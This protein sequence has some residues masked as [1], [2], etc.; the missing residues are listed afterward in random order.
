MLGAC[1][2]NTVDGSG[3]VMRNV[4]VATIVALAACLPPSSASRAAEPRSDRSSNLLHL[5]AGSFDTR[6]VDFRAPA[7]FTLAA[8]STAGLQMVQFSGAVR[9]EWLDQLATW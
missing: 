4:F 9:Q 1:C 5:T 2:C 6:N 8:P 3:E 7:P